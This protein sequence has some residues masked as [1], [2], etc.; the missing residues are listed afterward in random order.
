MNVA[1][2][3]SGAV[4]ECEIE[5]LKEGLPLAVESRRIRAPDFVILVD[6]IGIPPTG[7]E[8]LFHHEG[9]G[10]WRDRASLID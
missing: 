8:R 5:A 6:E 7:N 9:N 10:L 1:A 3:Q 2:A 4:A